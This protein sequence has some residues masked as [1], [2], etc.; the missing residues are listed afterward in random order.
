MSWARWLILLS[1]KQNVKVANNINCF[2]FSCS[3]LFFSKNLYFHSFICSNSLLLFSNTT[4]IFSLSHIFSWWISA[5]MLIFI[6]N[7]WIRS[8][9]PDSEL[10]VEKCD[11]EQDRPKL[12]GRTHGIACPTR[13]GGRYAPP[14]SQKYTTIWLKNEQGT[15][16][17]LES[18]EVFLELVT[19]KWRVTVRWKWS[20]A[21]KGRVFQAEKAD[22]MK[23]GSTMLT[24]L[25]I[26]V[27]LL[28]YGFKMVDENS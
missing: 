9:I 18:P 17:C 23:S 1:G 13:S 25:F 5:F 2:L 28:V 3:H 21:N 12:D 20:E 16:S 11:S 10:S 8:Y 19:L 27:Y 14:N 7:F 24:F 22:W 15:Y 6:K 4:S 26:I